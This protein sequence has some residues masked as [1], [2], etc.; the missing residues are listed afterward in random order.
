MGTLVEVEDLRNQTRA[1]V[2]K[3]GT[4]QPFGEVRV[5]GAGIRKMAQFSVEG[6][7]D[8]AFRRSGDLVIVTEVEFP[9][10]LTE[11]QREAIQRLF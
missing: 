1:V 6:M 11:K 9:D 7:L 3:A 10:R 8:K 2:L 4:V 5:K